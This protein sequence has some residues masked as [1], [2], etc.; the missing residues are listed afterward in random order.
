VS[1]RRSGSAAGK[2]HPPALPV[3]THV[4][5]I[6]HFEEMREDTDPADIDHLAQQYPGKPYP[7]RDRRRI[8]GDGWA[9]VL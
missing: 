2:A 4:S 6:G 9:G 5:I 1:R 8:A 7:Q 3:H